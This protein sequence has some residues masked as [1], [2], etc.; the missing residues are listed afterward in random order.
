MA[1]EADVWV[2]TAT[3]GGRRFIAAWGKEEDTAGH[4]QESRGKRG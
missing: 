3:E 2:E 4:R 1:L